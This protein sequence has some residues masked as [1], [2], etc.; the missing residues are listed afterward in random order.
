M[1]KQMEEF[2]GHASTAIF[3]YFWFYMMLTYNNN[4][5]IWTHIDPN[6]ELLNMEFGWFLYYDPHCDIFNSD[7]YQSI[8]ANMDFEWMEI[9]KKNHRIW[10]RLGQHQQLV[11]FAWLH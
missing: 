1:A 2:D 5:T 8:L 3:V 6:P 9:Q 11:T 7:E 4:H 10:M